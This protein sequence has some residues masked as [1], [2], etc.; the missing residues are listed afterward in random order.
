MLKEIVLLTI[1]EKED[2]YGVTADIYSAIQPNIY[3]GLLGAYIKSQDIAVEMLDESYGLSINELVN[4]LKKY[5]PVLVGVICSGANPS[6]STMS[7]VGAIKFFKAFNPNKGYTKTFIC[8]G[9]PTVLPERTIK[10]TGVDFVIRG[11]GYTT[12]VQLYKNI[13]NNK[14]IL[15]LPR[16]ESNEIFEGVACSYHKGTT[17]LTGI[18]PLLD[19][20]TLPVIDWH[21]MNPKR[22]RAHNWHTFEHIED[23]S[24]YGVIWTSFGC[25]Y[26]CSF[27]CI[28]N[29]FGERK[30][31]L[32]NM[33]SVLEE[34]DVLVTKYGVKNIKILDE[35]FIIKNKRIDEFIEGLEQ[36]G[37][38]LNMWAYARMDTVNFPLLKR[39]RKVGIKWIAFGMESVSQNILTNIQKGYNQNFYNDVIKMTQ[40]AGMYICADFI[41]GLWE[42]NYDT[43][44]ETYDF[45]VKHNFEWLNLYPA[46]AY[47]G[48]PMYQEYLNKGRITEPKDWGEY[49]LYGYSCVPLPTKYL[50]S[51]QVLKW[52]DTKFAE[53]HNRP[54]YLSMLENK[55]GIKTK[56]HI[57]DMLKNPLKRK[58]LE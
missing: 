38:D 28:N 7:M 53:Y 29:L 35:L 42:D 17:F 55:F 37:Y 5:H 4:Y 41:A 14:D 22:Y 52:R 12:I 25:P 31:R 18:P 8:G 48:T 9:H 50:T 33:Q 32:R 30:Y 46:F 36:R 21:T 27:C 11:E 13:L 15:T 3:M 39:L 6:S 2:L 58:I 19:V 49:A 26:N 16:L 1:N 54:E 51:A 10:E 43:L 24:P 44:Q 56:Q 34:I 57:I 20:D 40:D 45:A 23:R 47:P